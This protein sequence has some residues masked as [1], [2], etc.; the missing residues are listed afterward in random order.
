MFE[1]RE[2]VVMRGARQ[3]GGGGGGDDLI[4]GRVYLIREVPLHSGSLYTSSHLITPH[5]Y[6]VLK[7]VWRYPN[8][9]FIDKIREMRFTKYLKKII[10]DC[11]LIMIFQ[12]PRESRK[13]SEK[14]LYNETL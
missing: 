9:I 4:S 13:E 1:G 14:I 7:Q 5:L 6:R 12:I 10:T 3:L 11:C 2:S 8:N